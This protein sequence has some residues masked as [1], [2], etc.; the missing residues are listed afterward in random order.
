MSL[1]IS[2]LLIIFAGY[3]AGSI[4][5][6]YLTARFVAGMD[7]RSEGSGNIGATNIGR[8]LGAK[9]GILVLLLDC[10]KGLLPVVFVPRLLLDG[11]DDFLRHAEVICGIATIVGHMLPVWLRFRGGKGVATA[12]GVALALGSWATLA[13][14]CGFVLT[15]LLFRIVSLASMVA[16]VTFAVVQIVTL[17]P[18]PFSESQWSV[19]T[20]SLLVPTLILVRHRGNISRILRGEEQRFRWGSRRSGG[21]DEMSQEVTAERG[22]KHDV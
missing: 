16:A 15:M 10:L 3:L 13:A 1:P 4:P 2:I 20:F 5:F 12:L 18:N 9:W 17:L 14:L 8:V 11:Y 7:I 19:A 21:S 6:G 22:E